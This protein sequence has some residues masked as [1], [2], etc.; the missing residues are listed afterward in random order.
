MSQFHWPFLLGGMTF[1]FYGLRRVQQGL[2]QATGDKLRLILGKLTSNRFTSVIFGFLVTVVLQS[3]GATSAML[4]SLAESQLVTLS[5]AVAVVLGSGVGTTVTL[6]FLSIQGITE[7]ALLVT[8]LG[9]M[10]FAYGK[11]NVKNLGS[12]LFGFGLLFYGMFLIT[13]TAAPLKDSLFTQQ[14]MSFFAH[15]PMVT[16]LLSVL[17][18]SFLHSA[19]TIGIAIALSFSGTL[20]LE[21]A[22]PI[23][24]GANVGSCVTTLL[25]GLQMRGNGKRVAVAQ[26]LT[27]VIGVLVIYPFIPEV[28]RQVALLS[29]HLMLIT[30]LLNP[31]VAGGIVMAHVMFNFLLVL[32][33]LPVVGLLARMLTK[34]FPEEQSDDSNIHPMFLEESSLG[35]P[36]LAF[37]QVKREILR[38]AYLLAEELE[39]SL[40]IF[41]R[42]FDVAEEMEKVARQDDRIDVL[43]KA[44][45]FFLAKLST[46]ALTEKQASTQ[47]ALLTIG[48]DIEEIGDVVSKEIMTLARKKAF[49]QLTFSQEGWTDLLRLKTQT[50]KNFDLAI[51]VL[52]QPAEELVARLERQEDE[53]ENLAQE[54]RQSHLNRLNQGLKESL[55]TS[56]LHL[57]LISQYRSINHK[58]VQIAK[59]AEQI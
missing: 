5:N 57:E 46:K 45:R 31:G 54:L 11:R 44:I 29:A 3:S 16:L 38:I 7:Y 9:Y 28:T 21:H 30:P 10:F 24:L 4:V 34:F 56:T 47:L 35:T 53:M 41:D 43:E 33:F 12:V 13:S 14:I 32:L 40:N 22:I 59:H 48:Q 2:N 1:F 25:S 27:R 55:D 6:F 23:V 50:C 52:T 8:T 17:L 20:T 37:A 51:A 19:G 49:K 36:A 15:N 26:L 42:K 18:S 39:H 58:I